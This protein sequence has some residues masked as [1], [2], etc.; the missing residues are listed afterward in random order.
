MRRKDLCVLAVAV[1]VSGALCEIRPAAAGPETAFTYQGVL[2][3]AGHPLNADADL[4]CTLWDAETG[5]SQVGPLVALNA[6]DVVDGLFTVQLD[7]GVDPYTSNESR[8][9]EIE[10]RSPSGV[11]GFTTLSPRQRLTSSPFSTATRGISVDA[12]GN[13]YGSAGAA[14]GNDATVGLGGTWYPEYAHQFDL[15]ALVTDFSLGNLWSFNRTY[16]TVDPSSP[17][18]DLTF[19]GFDCE[20]IVPETQTSDF[21]LL[22]SGYTEVLNYGSGSVDLMTAQYAGNILQAP[23][24]ALSMSAVYGQ[25]WASMNAQV[26]SIKGLETYTLIG[27]DDLDTTTV[28][29]NTGLQVYSP[30]RYKAVTL[31][32]NYGIYLQDQNVADIENYAIYSEGGD[33]YLNGDLEVTGTVSKGAGSFK[34][35]HPLD[36]QNKYLYHSFV[37]SPDMKNIYDGVVTTDG[38]GYAQVRLPDW[39]TA[40]NGDFRYQLTVIGQF[41]QAI[42]AEEIANNQFWIRTDQPRVKVSWQ[43][44]G[45]RRDAYANANRIPVEQDKPHGARGR[46]LHPEAFGHSRA[47]REKRS[48]REQRGPII[49]PQVGKATNAHRQGSR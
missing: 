7:F 42:V 36:P 43:V 20:V 13:W 35:D 23:A 34:I 30:F 14:V 46:Y 38:S 27:F 45:I 3:E 6:V 5:G 37:E 19:Y 15:S 11:G 8:W 32:N 2:D 29:N 24:T 44:T 33:V 21:M 31:D 39:F 48:A 17:I 25:N 28:T 40:L 1:A 18:A 16:A 47:L 9:L 26:T 22:N 41:A 10:V 49:P 4:R 12:D